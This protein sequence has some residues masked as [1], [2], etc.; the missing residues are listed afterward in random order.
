[1]ANEILRSLVRWLAMLVLVAMLMN[2]VV[3]N[4]GP[5]LLVAVLFTAVRLL[6]RM[7]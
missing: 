3:G 1:M 6:W 2:V 4:F 5:L 7:R